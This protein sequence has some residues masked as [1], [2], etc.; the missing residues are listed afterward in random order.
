MAELSTARF[1]AFRQKPGEDLKRGLLDFASKN[2]IKAGAI[3]TCAGSLKQLHLRFANQESGSRKKGHFEIVS[4]TGT[5]SDS[6]AH[7]HLA[8]SDRRGATL[9]GHLLDGNL[10]YTT[11]EIVICSLPRYRFD[12]LADPLTGYRELVVKKTTPSKKKKR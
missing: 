9:G 6:T 10:I 2:K 12:R 7:L 1:Y 3:V 4:L 11:A 5:F 8:V